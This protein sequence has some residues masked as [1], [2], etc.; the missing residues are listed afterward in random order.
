MPKRTEKTRPATAKPEL[1]YVP[2]GELPKVFLLRDELAGWRAKDGTYTD[3]ILDA[4]AF[5]QAEADEIAANAGDAPIALDQAVREACRT[6]NPIIV[7][8]IAALGAR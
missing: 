5:S 8:A 4:A 2:E 1:T 7:A 6:G 3:S